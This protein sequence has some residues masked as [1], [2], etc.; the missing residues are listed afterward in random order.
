MALDATVR[1]VLLLLAAGLLSGCS[2]GGEAPSDD[3]SPTASPQPDA[4][5]VALPGPSLDGPLSVEEALAGRRSVRDYADVPVTLE[6]AAQLLWAA[7]GV[8]EPGTG[9]RSAPSAGA[10]YPLEVYLAASR[11]E[12]LSAGVYRYSPAGHTLSRVRDSVEIAELSRAAL[13]EDA[14]VQAPAVLVIAAVFERTTV[15]YGERGRRYV[16]M[17]AGHAAQNV[18]LQGVALGLGTVVIGA[19]DDDAVRSA[20]GLGAGEQPLYLMPFGRPGGG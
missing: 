1:G 17:E 3:A 2:T 6:E 16:H 5:A 13:S 20:V 7:Q 9:F 12:G 18:Y 14:I 10:L 15:K 8:T 19:F 11:I 4:A